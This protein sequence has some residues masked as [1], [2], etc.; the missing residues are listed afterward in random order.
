MTT[1]IALLRGINM[2]GHKVIK[3]EDLRKCFESMRF[4]YV[5][6]YVQ[7]GNVVFESME[8]N[9]A[10]LCKTIEQG[11]SN[12]FGHEIAVLI[13]TTEEIQT[14]AKRN[15]FKKITTHAE[16][17]MFVTFV[18]KEIRPKPKAPLFSTRRDVE[19][20]AVRG[21]EFFSL[22]HEVKGRGGFPNL[23]I[24]KEFAVT[25]TTRNWNTLVKLTSF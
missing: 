6:T 10:K 14:I 12:S 19:V 20:I 16:S 4:K 1:Y 5:R 2:A 8:S 21:R 24:E 11:L 15:P 25:A 13:R 17:K 3:M 23:F 22:S 9:T 18:S 7:S